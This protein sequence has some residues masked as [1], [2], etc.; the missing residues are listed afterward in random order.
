MK[1]LKLIWSEKEWWKV[2]N[3][4]IT[5]PL[6]EKARN[7]T[8]L[9]HHLVPGNP[10]QEVRMKYLLMVEIGM[11][12]NRN[13][14]LYRILYIAGGLLFVVSLSI[15]TDDGL[16]NGTTCTVKSFQYLTSSWNG[17]PSIIWLQSNNKSIGIQWRQ[18]YKKLYNMDIC[19][20]YQYLQSLKDFLF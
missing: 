4:C 10:C 16:I 15:K 8:I 17:I 13:F 2:Y 20:E 19:K 14:G 3:K 1:A 12:Y 6:E 5:L 7:T 11:N 9:A 18:R